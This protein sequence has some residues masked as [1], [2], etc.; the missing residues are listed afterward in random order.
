MIQL[1]SSAIGEVKRLQKKHAAN[2]LLRIGVETTGCKGLAYQMKFD[3]SPQPEDHIFDCEAIK[4]AV[5]SSSLQY[6][7]GLTLDYT[8]DLMGGGFRFYNP[9]AVETCTCGHSFAAG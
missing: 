2:G 5:D 9:N 4:I 6:L 1:S 3:Q 7:S 8:E